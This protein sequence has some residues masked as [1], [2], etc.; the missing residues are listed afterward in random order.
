MISRLQPG[1][2]AVRA[3]HFPREHELQCILQSV[4][5]LTVAQQ[6]RLNNSQA[7]M[8]ILASQA[9][10]CAATLRHSANNTKVGMSR[11]AET[12][13][14]R[15]RI[16]GQATLPDP[17]ACRDNWHHRL[18][19][20]AGAMFIF[21]AYVQDTYNAYLAKLAV[22]S[23]RA[24]HPEATILII[25]NASP[26][27]GFNSSAH[28]FEGITQLPCGPCQPAPKHVRSPRGEDHHQRGDGCACGA[29][30]VVRIHGRN[31]LREFGALAVAARRVASMSK[32]SRP[33]TLALVQH[34]TG[35][36][37]PV[38]FAR[39]PPHCPFVGLFIPYS[40]Q[41]KDYRAMGRWGLACSEKAFGRLGVD[42]GF[43][44][45]PPNA[46]WSP[47]SNGAMLIRLAALEELAAVGMFND[48]VVA[49]L[50]TRHS[51][52]ETNSGLLGA[53]LAQNRS[54]AAHPSY[55]PR[56][57]LL[58]AACVVPVGWKL[59][60]LNTIPGAV[61]QS[62]TSAALDDACSEVAMGCHAV[63]APR[64]PKG[65]RAPEDLEDM[66]AHEAGH[67]RTGWSH[68]A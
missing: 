22:R 67:H 19:S 26:Q 49:K 50:A 23:V 47:S 35:L 66:H 42:R 59:H 65:T 15:Q 64:Q 48:P 4:K 7:G 17:T 60:G 5:V 2:A 37:A 36:L 12:E 18:H 55:S 52:W 16:C 39:L 29:I 6:A 8:H 38:P 56:G 1:V 20:G 61:A 40:W 9:G 13:S 11:T 51:C 63:S 10:E 62:W 41:F 30:E 33:E 24:F 54:K 27:H 25:D 14:D 53:W 21:A 44:K 31:S 3:G 34:S 28:F 45:S 57:T 32:A 68:R 58:D 43:M 46:F